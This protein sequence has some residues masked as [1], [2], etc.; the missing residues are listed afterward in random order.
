MHTE[1][2]SSR[3]HPMNTPGTNLTWTELDRW[4]DAD[5]VFCQDVMSPSAMADAVMEDALAEAD[6]ARSLFLGRES[7]GGS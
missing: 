7:S 5:W 6:I 4:L 1:N 2:L 3:T